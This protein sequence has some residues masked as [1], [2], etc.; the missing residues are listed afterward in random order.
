MKKTMVFGA[1]LLFT[2]LGFAKCNNPEKTVFS[3]LTAKAKQIEVCDAGKTISYS[4]GY[5]NSKP[6]IVVAV[7]RNKATKE[8]LMGT[9]CIRSSVDV[10][11]GST[12]YRVYAVGTLRD[13]LCPEAGVEVISKQKTLAT[14]KCKS[15]ENITNNIADTELLERE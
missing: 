15:P 2:S 8:H 10:P 3:C 12:I 1:T 13:E 9:G 5:P 4:F 14:V 6:E 11:N 7:P